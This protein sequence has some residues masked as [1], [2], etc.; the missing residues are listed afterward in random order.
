[1]RVDD[2]VSDVEKSVDWGE[3]ARISKKEDGNTKGSA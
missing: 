2:G 3:G 1:M